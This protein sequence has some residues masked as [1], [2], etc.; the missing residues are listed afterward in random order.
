METPGGVSGVGVGGVGGV[1]GDVE[2]ELRQQVVALEERVAQQA[3]HIAQLQAW[4]LS[5]QQKE[6]E[7]ESKARVRAEMKRER[8]EQR[9]L[10]AKYTPRPCHACGELYLEA[11]NHSTACKVH[12]GKWSTVCRSVLMLVVYW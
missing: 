12:T 10:E 8:R 4:M 3:Q 6:A 11:E 2:R 7:A 9:K 1:S 5:C